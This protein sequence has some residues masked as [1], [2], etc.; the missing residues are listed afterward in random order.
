MLDFVRLL[1]MPAQTLAEELFEGDGARAWLYSSAM[2]SDV[3][4][5][6][7][8][9][10]IAAAYLNLLGHGVGW[11]S[12]EGGAGRL[13]GRARLPPA[14]ARRRRCAPARASR[15]SPER[16]RVAG[17]QLADGERLGAPRRGRRRDA[18]AL[19]ALA[20]D[21]LPARYAR[22]LRRYRI[23][24]ATLK[25]DWALAG[26]S[27]GAPPQAREAGTVHVGGSAAEVLPP[28]HARDGLP[29]RP[30]HAPR[31]AVACRSHPR[32]RRTHTAW[33][34]THGPHT[35]DWAPSAIAMCERMEA[36]LER[37]APGFRERIL[38]RHV[39]APGDLERRNANLVGGDVGG[40]SYM[41]DQVIF[42]PVPSLAPYRTPVRGLYIG[43]AATFPGGAVHGVP[44]RAAARLALAEGRVVA[45]AR[46]VRSV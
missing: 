2:H 22:A 24:P 23:G 11:P 28:R 10:A 40:G 37:F 1:L 12:P 41:L 7:S 33:A 36:Q 27:P 30:V 44:G 19:A 42:R 15:G 34:Y 26:R 45:L 16:G 18:R 4:P 39:L 17:V 25:V 13:A 29:E 35:V 5:R 8:G 14:R 20:D 21:A 38:A 43:S 32:S 3:P 9:S 46:R 6:A 31:P